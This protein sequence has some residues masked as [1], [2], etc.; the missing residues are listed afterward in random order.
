[1]TSKIKSTKSLDGAKGGSTKMF[2][3]MGV[4]PSQEGVSAPSRRPS[5]GNDAPKGGAGG[6]MGKQGGS[7]PS[8][9]GG[10]SVSK[11]GAGSNSDFSVHG[12]NGHMFGKSSAI[13]GRPQ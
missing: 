1:M 4:Q 7:R 6:V 8:T 13:T 9:P 12:G 10:V 5:P 11:S 3:K 2:T